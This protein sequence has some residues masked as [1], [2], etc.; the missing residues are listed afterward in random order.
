[1]LTGS[2][3]T[4]KTWPR[5]KPVFWEQA[6]VQP[7]NL[8]FSVQVLLLTRGAHV[9][10]RKKEKKKKKEEDGGGALAGGADVDGGG[11]GGG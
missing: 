3:R 11:G 7:P 4:D 2:A 6:P 9:S 1:M 10:K 5:K 8:R